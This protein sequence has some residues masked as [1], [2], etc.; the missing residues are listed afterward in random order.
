LGSRR[1]LQQQSY[2]SLPLSPKNGLLRSAPAGAQYIGTSASFPPCLQ[3]LQQF[4]QFI[5][6]DKTEVNPKEYLIAL[7]FAENRA[8]QE[9]AEAITPAGLPSYLSRQIEIES[10]KPAAKISLDYHWNTT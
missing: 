6:T 7:R 5:S 8:H 2:W 1:P 10:M 4:Y 9:N 3:P